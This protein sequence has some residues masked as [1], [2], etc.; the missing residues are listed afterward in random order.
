[1]AGST[2]DVKFH[3]MEVCEMKGEGQQARSGVDT[4]E[5]GAKWRSQRPRRSQGQNLG[6]CTLL[7]LPP[8]PAMSRAITSA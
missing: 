4:K 5:G 2:Y 7:I 3:T 8:I 1:M 6:V